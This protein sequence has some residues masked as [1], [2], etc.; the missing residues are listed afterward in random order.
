MRLTR[1]NND[2]PSANQ[3]AVASMGGNFAWMTLGNA[4][5]AACQ[6]GMV[7][8]LARLGSPEIVGQYALGV[9]VSTPILMLAQL[10]LRTVLATDVAAEH[11]FLDYRDVRVV[12][13]LLALLGIAAASVFESSSQDRLAVVLVAL[14][15]SVEWIA[16]IYIGLFQQRERMKRIAIS[17]SLHG[18]LSVTALAVV[19]A[20]TGQLAAGLL[21]V[22]L[23]RLLALFLYD[24]TFA[25]RG[26]LMPRKPGSASVK[27]R[28]TKMLQIVKTALPLGVV[29]MIGSFASN[30]PRYFIVNML[31]R[32]ALGIFAGLA[33]LTT[34]ANLLVTALGQAATPRLAR[35]YQDGD[36]AAFGRM[37]AQVAGV[38]VLLGLCTVAGSSVAG[39]SI[40][41]LLFGKEYAA[42][43]TILVA[44]SAAAGAGFVA[45]LL[46]YVITAGRRFNE[47]MPLQ[48]AAVGGTSLGCLLLIPR[49]GL[50]G[51]AIA[52]GAGFVVQILGELWVLRSI[53]KRPTQQVFSPLLEEPAFE[54]GLA[55]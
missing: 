42:Q 5:Y 20:V 47:Q 29:L 15:Q 16:D 43:S 7:S 33:S 31:G 2:D 36:R 45:S 21:G 18:V 12:T 38:G 25:T 27:L 48:L 9:A 11:H 51:G 1:T 40:L 24:S 41:G 34:A 14:A 13:I 54:K 23:V 52:I 3:P 8:V 53:L 32:H 19:V 30:V 6:W 35:F 55:R 4:V 17:L 50:L 44:L 22:L 49:F 37:S 10:N 26:C 28:T 46:G 39:R